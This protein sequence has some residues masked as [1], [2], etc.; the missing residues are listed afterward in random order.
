V[1]TYGVGLHGDDTRAGADDDTAT[2]RLMPDASSCT[3]RV[4]GQYLSGV[5]E[6]RHVRFD[7]VR[8]YAWREGEAEL[9]ACRAAPDDH[10]PQR[11]SAPRDRPGDMCVEPIDP[12]A[13][14]PCGE[15]VV[16]DA[17]QVETADGGADVE[18][19]DVVRDVRSSLDADP[20]R[21]GIDR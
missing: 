13:D 16:A 12:V 3:R 21:R 9:D 11:R 8:T 6:D 1:E 7:A 14:R 15:R 4:A 20:P 10:D 5:R 2:V 19:R 18:A 17:G